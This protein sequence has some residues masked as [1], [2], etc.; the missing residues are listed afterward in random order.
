MTNFLTGSTIYKTRNGTIVKLCRR[1]ETPVMVGKVVLNRII[2]YYG[3]EVKI[4]H[5]K[6]NV[7]FEKIH[8]NDAGS[9]QF[10]E[11]GLSTTNPDLDLMEAVLPKA[12]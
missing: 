3:Y 10:T 11:K 8:L 2:R 4:T 7:T 5:L 6:E 12:Y 9:L 1:T